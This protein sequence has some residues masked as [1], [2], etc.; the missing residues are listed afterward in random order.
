MNADTMNMS[1]VNSGRKILKGALMPQ[2]NSDFL[3]FDN[4]LS[5]LHLPIINCGVG[6]FLFFF[7]LFNQGNFFLRN[8]LFLIQTQPVK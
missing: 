8:I 5:Q 1:D 6:T 7:F 2:D 3:S 4:K